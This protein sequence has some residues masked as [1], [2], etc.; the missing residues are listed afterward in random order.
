VKRQQARKRA[1]QRLQAKLLTTSYVRKLLSRGTD[2][3]PEDFPLAIVRL[4]RAKLRLLRA[5]RPMKKGKQK[6]G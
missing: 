1:Y 2:L 5:V 6:N 3:K 4:A